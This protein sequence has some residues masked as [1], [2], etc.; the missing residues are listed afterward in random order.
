[1]EEVGDV[2]RVPKKKSYEY[3]KRGC[4]QSPLAYWIL[5]D[6]LRSAGA[7]PAISSWRLRGFLAWSEKDKVR[8]HE[9]EHGAI[10]WL[11]LYTTAVQHTQ[12]I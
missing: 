5:A 1:M 4:E 8:G 2:L 10:G 3:R 7:R 11:G 12:A 9:V 6:A